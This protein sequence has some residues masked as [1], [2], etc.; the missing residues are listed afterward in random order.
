ML[1]AKQIQELFEVLNQK[2]FEQGEIGEIGIIG[3]AVMCLVYQTR[4]ATRD[5]DA[6][7]HPSHV[8]RKLADEIAT[9]YHLD[10]DWLNDAAKGYLRDS[11]QKEDVLQLSNLRVWA[12]EPSYMLCMKCMSA[13]WDT[14]DREDVISLI[15]HL[16]LKNA[17]QV[18]EI[19]ESFYPKNKIPPKTQ[20][21]IEEVFENLK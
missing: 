17:K 3:G 9:E 6:I 10:S 18:F 1:S 11:F 2:L 4:Q 21:F 20:F 5:I 19:I 16:K 7:F 8:I 15:R 14:H 13:R 12:P